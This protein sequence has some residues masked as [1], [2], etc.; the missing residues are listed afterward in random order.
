MTKSYCKNNK[1]T[2]ENFNRFDNKK[3]DKRSIRPPDHVILIYYNSGCCTIICLIAKKTFSK[4]RKTSL[5]MARKQFE[6][7]TCKVPNTY[8]TGQY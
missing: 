8:D 4:L 5:L 2:L 6:G 3:N 7:N 1:M